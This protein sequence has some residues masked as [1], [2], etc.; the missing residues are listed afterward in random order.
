MTS[1]STSDSNNRNN[2]RNN[3]VL[4]LCL[5]GCR[6]DSLLKAAPYISKTLLKLPNSYYNLECR[7]EIPISS[8]CWLSLLT[9][10]S[11][12]THGIINNSKHVP[13]QK[14]SVS[15]LSHLS[16][17]HTQV[18]HRGWNRFAR[19]FPSKTPTREVYSVNPLLD[20][21][22]LGRSRIPDYLCYYDSSIDDTGHRVGFSNTLDAYLD[23]ITKT[24]RDVEKI[25]GLIEQRSKKYQE[26]WLVVIL[27]DHGGTVNK[28]KREDTLNGKKFKLG[29][30]DQ[31][32]I[33]RHHQYFQIYVRI[34]GTGKGRQPRVIKPTPN[35][36]YPLKQTL[37]HINKKTV[38]RVKTN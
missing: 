24:D 20:R 29:T 10:Q 12:K 25:F 34:T 35:Y 17:K 1:N 16:D 22:S 18:Y 38:S 2:N 32:G 21:L 9:G 36:S 28:N 6:S 27:T 19:F 14:I 5:D 26:D 7:N 23:S 30:H 4:W 37:N 8:P 15:S 11:V 13:P 3:K 33:T 31:V